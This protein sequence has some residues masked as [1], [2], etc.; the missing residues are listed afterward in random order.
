[1]SCPIAKAAMA[2]TT[3]TIAVNMF[4]LATPS[5]LIELIKRIN[6]TPEHNTDKYS[7]GFNISSVIESIVKLGKSNIKK[8][9][10]KNSDPRMC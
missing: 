2:D 10:R 4:A 7:R 1:M 9:G 6:A 8:S 5:A 3:G